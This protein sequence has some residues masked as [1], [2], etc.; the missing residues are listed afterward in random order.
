[1]FTMLA[2][3]TLREAK[4]KGPQKA[5]ETKDPPNPGE[6][7][8]VPK[9]PDKVKK[10][11]SLGEAKEKAPKKGSKTQKFPPPKPNKSMKVPPGTTGLSGKSKVKSSANSQHAEAPRK[12]KAVRLW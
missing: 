9:M 2:L 11:L 4:E 5:S 8:K 10:S 7:R 6:A 1:M 12:R 3:K